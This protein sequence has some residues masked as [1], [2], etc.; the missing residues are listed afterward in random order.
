MRTHLINACSL[1]SHL[2]NIHSAALYLNCCNAPSAACSLQFERISELV[3]M[4]HGRLGLPSGPG[5][6]RRGTLGWHAAE[7]SMP[8]KCTWQPSSCMPSLQGWNRAFC[9]ACT[10]PLASTAPGEAMKKQDRLRHTPHRP[11]HTREL[12][13]LSRALPRRPATV[14]PC[15]RGSVSLGSAPPSAPSLPA[16][17]MIAIVSS[18]LSADAPVRA[19]AFLIARLHGR[20]RCS[21]REVLWEE[22]MVIRGMSALRC[23]VL[24]C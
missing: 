12:S 23:P 4:R 18:S 2:S 5:L 11:S 24:I 20:M 22:A 15:V 17:L 3:Y 8:P 16:A 6:R 1:H 14:G 7:H 19:M 9:G 10:P 13:L 21:D